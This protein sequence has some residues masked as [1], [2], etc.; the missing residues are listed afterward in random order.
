MFESIINDARRAASRVIA[1]YLGRAVVA[2]PFVVAA[3]FATAGATLWLIERFGAQLAY[4]ILALGFTL[5]GLIASVVVTVREEEVEEAAAA[6]EKEAAAA[7]PLPAAGDVLAPVMALLP[8]LS[9]QF[10]MSAST[11][12]VRYGFKYLPVLVLAAL[13]GALLWPIEKAGEGAEPDAT[14]SD[15]VGSEPTEDVRTASTNGYASPEASRAH[16]H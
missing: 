1:T 7:S 6:E 2:V 14:N 3:G 8:L 16:L 5:L 11:K 9:S 12:V 10:G 4:W 15:A 13:L